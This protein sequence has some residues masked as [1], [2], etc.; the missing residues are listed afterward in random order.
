LFQEPHAG[1]EDS[2]NLLLV[3]WPK[4]TA[5]IKILLSAGV[6]KPYSLFEAPEDNS[7]YSFCSHQFVLSVNR[8]TDSTFSHNFTNNGPDKTDQFPCHSRTALNRQ[9]PFVD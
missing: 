3:S 9:L 4:Y 5:N 6:E 7:Y 8:C 1:I 2:P